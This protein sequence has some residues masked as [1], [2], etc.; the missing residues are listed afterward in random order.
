MGISRKQALDCFASDDLVGIGME[1]DAV[2]RNL[3]PEGVVTYTVQSSLDCTGFTSAE[4]ANRIRV[5]A[6]KGATC[7]RFSGLLPDGLDRAET[8]I[9]QFRAQFPALWIEAFSTTEIASL[10]NGS[11]PQPALA[12]LRDAG[13]NSIAA[14][15]LPA[16]EPAAWP[17]WLE[18]HRTAHAERLPSVAAVAFAPGEPADQRVDLLA[19]LRQLQDETGGFTAFVPIAAASPSGRD[20]DAMTAVDRL[21]TLAIARMFLDN[22][23]NTQSSRVSDGLKVLQAGLRF[24]ANDVGPA[25]GDEEDIRRIIRDAGFRPVERDAAY[26]TMFL[27]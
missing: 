25:H 15:P 9:R 1:A 22:V 16:S 18:V 2:R 12:R 24:G 8:L 26:R 17:Q 6:D 5:D 19:F 14:E 20:L 10:S 23:P 3:H 13:L 7:I 11:G 27:N 4:L 21:K